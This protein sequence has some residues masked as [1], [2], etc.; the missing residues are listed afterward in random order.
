M[1]AAEKKVLFAR[2]GSLQIKLKFD[3]FIALANTLSSVNVQKE[4]RIKKTPPRFC[5]ESRGGETTAREKAGGEVKLIV[6][7]T[8]NLTVSE[9]TKP[10]K[11]TNAFAGLTRACE[12]TQCIRVVKVIHHFFFLRSSLFSR[13]S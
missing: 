5:G 12:Y 4:R 11:K 7:Y 3:S 13:C 8:R 6:N 1:Y 10:K 2:R 9:L